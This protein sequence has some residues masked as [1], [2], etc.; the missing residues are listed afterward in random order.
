MELEPLRKRN[1]Q[2]V[3]YKRRTPVIEAIIRGQNDSFE[4]LL[5]RARI[6]KRQHPDYV[7]SE[8]L[9][10]HI[11]R[12]KN[13]DSETRF[14][15]LL[16]IINKR[17]ADSC[18][19]PSRQVG[20]QLH[21]DAD[22]AER[23]EATVNHVMELILKDQDGYEERLDVYEFAFDKAVRARRIDH[24][25]MRDRRP[26]A[27]APILD[28]V[29]REVRQDVED[30]LARISEGK[31]PIETSLDCRIALRRAIDT[32]SMGQRQVIELEMTGMKT[33]TK[34][35]GERS[36]SKTLGCSVRTVQNRR[37]RAF[38]AMREV[39]GLENYD[40]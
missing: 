28:E 26:K 38:A 37:N 15:A 7:P 20:N 31:T 4:T 6:R 34:K 23:R 30:A 18:R 9:V 35:E 2:G 40:E 29:S 5:E 14:L 19:R 11:R 17:V 27:N 33:E 16:Q 24:K 13:E 21:E 39:L 25:R 12:T 8:A 1:G 22:L 36:I 32:L 10:Y 3:L